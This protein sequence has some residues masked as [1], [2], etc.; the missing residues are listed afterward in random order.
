[1]GALTPHVWR[2]GA[3]PARDRRGWTGTALALFRNMADL[4]DDRGRA[5]AEHGHVDAVA[6]AE[7]EDA[8][9]GR[10]RLPVDGE[11]A[12]VDRVAEN[13]RRRAVGDVAAEERRLR[14]S[15]VLARLSQA[16]D[17]GFCVVYALLGLRFL[18]ALVAAHN[19]PFV[20]VLLAITNPLYAPFRG[21]MGIWTIGGV[22]IVPSLV[23]AAIVYMMVHIT[24]HQ[25]LHFIARPRATI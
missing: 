17:F 1:M 5:A 19:A 16:I 20:R 14:L 10:A 23:V 18:L 2:G 7:V 11:S 12:R 6:R 22:A 24:V 8:V 25:L 21:V 4:A 15:R 9:S 3:G 13:V